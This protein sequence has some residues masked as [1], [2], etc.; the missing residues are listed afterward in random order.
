MSRIVIIYDLLPLNW[1][2]DEENNQLS[3]ERWTK[4]TESLIS[5]I[6]L[7]NS[8]S[9]QNKVS[10]IGTSHSHWYEKIIKLVV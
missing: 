5:F 6:S 7:F 4:T 8:I 2:S 10:L 9:I 1:I 3:F